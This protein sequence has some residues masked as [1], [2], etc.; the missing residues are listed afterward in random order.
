[1]PL[2]ILLIVLL[3]GLAGFAYW[4]FLGNP[5]W[6]SGGGISS[7]IKGAPTIGINSSDNVSATV[8]FKFETTSAVEARIDYGTDISYAKSS[9]WETNYAT[10]HTINLTGLNFGSRYYYRILTR[11]K[12]NKQNTTE[13]PAFRAGSS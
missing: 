7:V 12:N 5:P 3:I 1:M 2:I 9:E 10:S 11:D 13:F 6:S 8:T 4:A